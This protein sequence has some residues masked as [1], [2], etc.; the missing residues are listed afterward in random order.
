MAFF[1]LL[2]T[3]AVLGIEQL[4]QWRF[5]AM[6]LVCLFLIGVGARTRNT[7]CLSVGAVVFVLLMAQT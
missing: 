4:L 3:V 1:Q 6:G 7:T 5:G 2:T